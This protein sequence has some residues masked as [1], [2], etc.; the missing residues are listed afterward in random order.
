MK[1]PV[2]W[3]DNPE[4][5]EFATEALERYAQECEEGTRISAR[6]EEDDYGDRGYI[7]IYMDGKTY[8]LDLFE[9]L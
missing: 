5:F 7:Y 1:A 3:V 2:S 9:I 6:D 4:V 8:T